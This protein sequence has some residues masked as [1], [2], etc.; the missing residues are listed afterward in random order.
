MSLWEYRLG[1]S[2]HAEWLKMTSTSIVDLLKAN[3]FGVGTV[4][5][6]PNM[7][8]AAKSAN[9]QIGAS[10]IAKELKSLAESGHL[11]EHWILF[12]RYGEEIDIKPED[13]PSEPDGEFFHPSTGTQIYD[14]RERIGLC[15]TSTEKFRELL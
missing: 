11:K 8:D 4:Y 14:W 9:I 3:Y 12:D 2:R 13:V 10:A 7:Y 1:P 15:Y 6:T 5:S